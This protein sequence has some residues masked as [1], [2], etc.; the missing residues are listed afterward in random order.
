MIVSKTIILA[1]ALTLILHSLIH[2]IGTIVYT[3]L[4]VVEGISYKTT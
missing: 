3:K 4:G 1:A 2:L